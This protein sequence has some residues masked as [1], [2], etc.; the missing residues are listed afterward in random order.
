MQNG[1]SA[2]QFVFT[3]QQNQMAAQSSLKT[4]LNQLEVSLSHDIGKEAY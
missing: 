3:G 4:K 1:L 2:Q